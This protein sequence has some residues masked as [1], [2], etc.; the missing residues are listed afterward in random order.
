MRGGALPH[1]RELAELGLVPHRVHARQ[2]ARQA[3]L[4]ARDIV[5]PEEPPAVGDD[6]GT[7]NHRSDERRTRL[8]PTSSRPDTGTAG[9]LDLPAPGAP[10][11]AS[12]GHGPLS[13]PRAAHRG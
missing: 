1:L 13:W 8:R 3:H 2:A 11:A 12:G 7:P 5:G 6:G 10:E 9:C 4:S